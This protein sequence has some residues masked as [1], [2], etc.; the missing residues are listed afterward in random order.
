M[1]D[2]LTNTVKVVQKITD[3]IF[4]NFTLECLSGILLQSEDSQDMECQ[5]SEEIEVMKLKFDKSIDPSKDFSVLVK[6]EL[7]PPKRRLL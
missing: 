3:P 1:L 4:M 6:S 5:I 7:V 2:P